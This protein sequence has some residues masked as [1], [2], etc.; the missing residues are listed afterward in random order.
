MKSARCAA[1]FVVVIGTGLLVASAA[2][3]AYD[4]ANVCPAQAP[5]KWAGSAETWSQF[6]DSCISND[7]S[8]HAGRAFDRR[9][10]DNCIKTCGLANDAEGR[11]PPTPTRESKSTANGSLA[12][13][14]WCSDVP[15]SPAPPHYKADQW[16]YIRNQCMKKPGLDIVCFDTCVAAKGLWQGAKAATPNATGT[17]NG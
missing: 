2:A 15:A 13:P 8:A 11:I 6:V 12:N 10:W 5:P 4:F 3:H 17:P 9:F 14:N 1:I 16:A 7:A